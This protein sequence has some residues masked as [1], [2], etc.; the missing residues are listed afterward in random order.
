MKTA[1]TANQ[2]TRMG[3]QYFQDSDHYR[4]KDATLWIPRLQALGFSWLVLKANTERA[5]P[6]YFI[7]ALVEADIEPIL[8]FNGLTL[9][10]NLPGDVCT[11]IE[12]YAKWGIKYAVLFDRPNCR[13]FWQSET[14]MQSDLVER[15][16]DAFIPVA[17][18]VQ[19]S[20]ISPVFPPLE[21][22][23]D[24]WDTA[25]LREALQGI[26]RRDVNQ[27]PANLTL[28]A[29]VQP[30]VKPIS[31]GAGGPERWPNAVPYSTSTEQEDQCGFNIF[32]WYQSVAHAIFDTTL[33]IMLLEAKST[34]CNQ[35]SDNVSVD[36]NKEH[37]NQCLVIARFLTENIASISASLSVDTGLSDPIP[38]EVLCFNFNSLS[39]PS[40]NDPNVQAWFQADGTPLAIAD[41]FQQWRSKTPA[42]SVKKS[43][44]VTGSSLTTLAHYVLIPECHENLL[45]Y[46]LDVLRPYLI[47]NK[48]VIGFSVDEALLAQKITV[49]GDIQQYPAGT[50]EKILG[51]GCEVEQLF[52]DGTQIASSIT[53]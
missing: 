24:Y 32:S 44:P 33:P 46:Y 28:S 38:E 52:R 29:Y 42:Q 3:M 37:D 34:Q 9:S 23:G 11:L 50:L 10:S 4:E 39:S 13:H 17:E 12:P 7:Q 51:S 8:H 20:G 26:A 21:P 22:G 6:E 18:V 36:T 35:P 19:K 25:F 14:W 53:N 43:V 15:F 45:A 47:K 5:I 41:L 48:P 27:L 40:E 1:S 31:W 49:I 16:L 2:P 30:G